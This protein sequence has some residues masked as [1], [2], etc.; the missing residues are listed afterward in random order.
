MR[1]HKITCPPAA[2]TDR[3]AAAVVTAH[4]PMRRPLWL[5]TR[6]GIGDDTLIDTVFR[7]QHAGN[8]CEAA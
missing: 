8:L 2:L 3:E 1:Q 7:P 5:R 4:P 6:R